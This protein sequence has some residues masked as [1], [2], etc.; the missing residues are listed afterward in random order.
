MNNLRAL[1]PPSKVEVVLHVV[2]DGKPTVL[3][4]EMERIKECSVETQW[5]LG[6]RQPDYENFDSRDAYLVRQERGPLHFTLKVEALPKDEDG[7][8]FRL[9]ITPPPGMDT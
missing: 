2:M 9:Q 1:E 8:T 7:E 4:Y 5:N 6:E 3:R